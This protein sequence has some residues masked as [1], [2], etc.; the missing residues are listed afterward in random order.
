MHLRIELVTGASAA[1]TPADM[2]K[3]GVND[4]HSIFED[5]KDAKT[6]EMDT[7]VPL[8]PLEMDSPAMVQQLPS[9]SGMTASGGDLPPEVLSDINI[10]V[11]NLLGVCT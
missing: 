11:L 8:L 10:H 6:V 7:Q 9:A 5:I 1:V 4:I 2:L 3:K